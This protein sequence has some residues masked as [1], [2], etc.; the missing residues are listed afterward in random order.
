MKWSLRAHIVAAMA[1]GLAVIIAAGAVSYRSL[2]NLL[3]TLSW[4]RPLA[5][6]RQRQ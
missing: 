3:A 2:Q 6:C 4:F 1:L 5:T